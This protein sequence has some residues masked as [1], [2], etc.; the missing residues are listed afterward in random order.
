LAAPPAAVQAEIDFLLASVENS[1]CEFFRN[2]TWHDA[3]AAAEHLRQKFDYLEARDRIASTEDFIE[4]AGTRSS[5]SGFPYAVKCADGV[6]VPSN[7][8]LSNL[9]ARHRAHDK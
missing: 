5:L 8:W 4:G 9:L 7:L 3:R 6:T 2:G 1:G